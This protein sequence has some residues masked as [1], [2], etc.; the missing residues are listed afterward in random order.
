MIQH[1]FNS[2]TLSYPE[3]ESSS[4]LSTRSI[5]SVSSVL[6]AQTE[7][8]NHIPDVQPCSNR[9]SCQ[10]ERQNGAAALLDGTGK[11]S[12]AVTE[13]STPEK[14]DKRSVWTLISDWFIWEALAIILSIAL[15][16]AIVGILAEFD[17]KPQ[18]S[19]KYV[20]LNTV[21][22]WLSTVSK[23]CVLYSINEALG[24]LKWVWF[25]EKAR[26]LPHLRTFDRASRGF[27]GSVELVWT[28]HAKYV[29]RNIQ[30]KPANNV[31][32]SPSGA[33]WLPF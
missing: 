22:S 27:L 18:P 29:C 3:V 25:A 15:L 13:K 1:Q 4:S 9:L 26:P 8:H 32:T 21:V 28:L 2:S 12:L 30:D 5:S 11:P 33:A 19:W 14:E 31:D 23:A 7:D 20:S 6:P 24:Q 16:V 17:Q 10:T